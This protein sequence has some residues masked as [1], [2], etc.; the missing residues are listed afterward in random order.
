MGKMCKVYACVLALIFVLGLAAQAQVAPGAMKPRVGDRAAR[1]ELAGLGDLSLLD[2]RD[3]KEW[4]FRNVCVRRFLMPP[5][6]GEVA[7]MVTLLGL[8][9]PQKQQIRELYASF[10]ATV[11]PILEQRAAATKELFAVLQSQTPSK[12]ALNAAY[13]KIEQADKAIVNAEFDFWIALRQILNPQQQQQ[14][15]QFMQRKIDR[16]ATPRTRANAPAPPAP[17]PPK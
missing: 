11:R 10:V 12:D 8:T 2:T 13:D 16:E 17:Q 14:M 6:R 1:P 9:D 15:M 4:F 3:R 5:A 7:Q